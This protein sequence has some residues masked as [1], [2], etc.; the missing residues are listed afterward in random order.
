MPVAQLYDRYNNLLSTLISDGASIR[1]S[2]TLDG[3]RVWQ[4]PHKGD[5][6]ADEW[7]GDVHHLSG[8]NS[9]IA[10]FDRT[11]INNDYKA[12]LNTGGARLGGRVAD[13]KVCKHQ[14]D[15][16]AADERATSLRYAS[17]VRCAMMAGARR[18]GHGKSVTGVFA[19]LIKTVTDNLRDG[20]S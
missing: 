5:V 17:P 12:A 10:A 8:D 11:E 9:L 19:I 7:D 4:T 2:Y 16:V 18:E 20:Y 13:T 3:Q 14:A 15:Y 6:A 1:Q